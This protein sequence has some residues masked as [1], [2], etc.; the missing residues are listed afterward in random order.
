MYPKTYSW[1]RSAGPLQQPNRSADDVFAGYIR[2]LYIYNIIFA[3]AA[4][5]GVNNILAG[6]SGCIGFFFSFHCCLFF[7]LLL[8][9][10]SAIE[11]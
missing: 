2:V 6:S 11:R 5:A 9:I 1:R 7:R 4:T 10:F 3:H 8:L